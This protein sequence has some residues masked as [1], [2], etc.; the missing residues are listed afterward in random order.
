[1]RASMKKNIASRI[2]VTVAA[3]SMAIT[4]IAAQANTRAGDSAALY[5]QSTVAQPGTNRQAEGEELIGD[6]AWL[7]ALLAALLATAGV[8]IAIDDDDNQSPGT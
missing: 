7:L 5:S 4:P 1:M 3:A 6:G 2:A 8:I